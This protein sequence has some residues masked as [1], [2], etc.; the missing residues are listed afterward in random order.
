MSTVASTPPITRLLTHAALKPTH[1][2]K[3]SW[4]THQQN[5]FGLLPG[6][7]GS[8]P[9]STTEAGGCGHTPKGLKLPVCYVE[10]S[11][12]AYP[13]VRG[14]L[15]HNMF[16]MRNA[17]ED[18]MY[19]LLGREF[20]RFRETERRRDKPELQYR[21]HWSGDF[22]SEAYVRAMM[23]AMDD[24]PD[25]RFWTYTRSFGPRVGFDVLQLTRCRNLALYMSLDPTNIAMGLD[26]FYE[27]L[28]NSPRSRANLQVC[29]MSP[30]NDFA[31]RWRAAKHTTRSR[32]NWD[33]APPFMP[34]C[35]VDTGK[36]ALPLAC[37][38]CQMCT[39]L[40]PKLQAIWFQ[41]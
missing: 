5:T 9:G 37:S 36:M 2:R 25:V 33:A 28:M 10:K 4:R 11:M 14:V 30:V 15:S 23:R 19:M 34:A 24:Y 31:D 7:S 17:T 41:T 29:Y 32:Q 8:C 39:G 20:D 21:L 13:A 12:S 22:F 27:H 38:R 26:V 35:P 40:R 1:D 3:T 6:L 18:E 16:L